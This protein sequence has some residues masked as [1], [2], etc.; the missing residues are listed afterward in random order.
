[1]STGECAI[2]LRAKIALSLS[3]T[4]MVLLFLS[5]MNFCSMQARCDDLLA[6]HVA[7]TD[8]LGAAHETIAR[9]EGEKAALADSV[10]TLAER[11]QKLE[12]FKRTLI[13]SL[14][15]SIRSAILLACFLLKQQQITHTC[16][17]ARQINPCCQSVMPSSSRC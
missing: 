7:L 10:R 3:N 13:A 17:G 15:V 2:M 11:V 6:D 4:S 1:M 8:D 5:C 9:L 14:Q 16:S 12:A